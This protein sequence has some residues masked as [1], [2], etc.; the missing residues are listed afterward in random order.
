MHPASMP[1]QP[2]V[3]L[4]SGIGG[5][6]LGRCLRQKGI[7]SIIYDKA[8]SSPRHSYGI[9]LH[10][11]AYK[12][13]LQ[14][15]GI[16]EN[17][18]RRRIAVDSLYH[19]GTGKAYPEGSTLSGDLTPGIFRANR[20]KLEGLLREG[21]DIHREHALI[22]AKASL[23]GAWTKL[24]FQND[25]E[26]NS[27][28]IVDALGVHSPLRKSLLPQYSLEV[29]PFVVFC[30]KRVVK[31]DTFRSTYAPHLKD[32]N[33][34]QLKPEKH[35]DVLLQ[36][37]VNDHLPGGDVSINYVYSRPA[38]S[39]APDLLHNPE[40]PMAGATDIP[41]AFYDELESVFADSELEEPF[42]SMFDPQMIRRER[43]LHWL[44]RCVLVSADDLGKLA[45]SGV[46]MI[47]DSA[48][49]TPILGGKGANHAMQ[50]A[51]ELAE[52]ISA[53]YSDESRLDKAAVENFY[54][55]CVGR[56]REEVQDSQKSIAQMHFAQKA[57]L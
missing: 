53:S 42:P 46:V 44:M 12:P 30:G 32:A 35:E 41:A 57:V 55:M 51:I 25:L 2:I 36:I 22:D 3:I 19:A 20:S 54:K 33:M 43:L 52:V 18:F 49:A 21:Q 9:T 10:P 31:P 7:P 27:S 6:T 23:E 1:K 29:L 16:D 14:V 15:L 8:T 39:E 5:L 26:I 37:W 28:F 56:W 24:T 47:G 13:L 48:H 38:R 17:S 45:E 4:G 11:W 40:R 50:D 34:L